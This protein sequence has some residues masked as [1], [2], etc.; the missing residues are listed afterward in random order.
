MK[1]AD[2]SG[3]FF[4]LVLGQREVDS[5]E[6]ALKRLERGTEEAVLLRDLAAHLLKFSSSLS[7]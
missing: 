2:K 7:T 1:R 3:A 6:A 4:A 5:G